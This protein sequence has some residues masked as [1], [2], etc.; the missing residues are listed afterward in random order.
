MSPS[1][2]LL[3]LDRDIYQIVARYLETETNASLRSNIDSFTIYQYIQNSNS[4]LRRRPKSILISSIDRAL[5]TMERE[6]ENRDP[7]VN[8]NKAPKKKRRRTARSTASQPTTDITIDDMGGVVHVFQQLTRK[9]AYPLHRPELLT[10]SNAALPHGILLHGPPGCGKTTIVR[11]VA[12]EAGVP[13]VEVQ[14]SSIVSSMSGE[15]EANIRSR[16]EEAKELA[17]CLLFIDDID[18]ISPKRDTSQAQMDKRM[19]SQLISCMDDLREQNKK[20]RPVIVLAATNRPGSLDPALRIGGRFGTEISI[21]VPDEAAREAILRA[22][23]RKVSYGDDVDFKKLAK[24]TVGY[25]GADLQELV[26]EAFSW[27]L[28]QYEQAMLNQEKEIE[29]DMEVD[30]VSETSINNEELKKVKTIW[31]IVKDRAKPSPPGFEILTLSMQSFIEVLP[32][33]LPFAKRQGFAAVPETTW[34]DIGALDDVREELEMSVVNQILYPED[35]AAV[36]IDAPTG[37]LLWGPPGCGKTLLA[38]ATANACQA[39]FINVKGSELLNKVR[40]FD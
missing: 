24:M 30:G 21:G 17:P 37:V 23:L 20:G 9:L 31:R 10:G 2:L 19:V 39:N 3:Q 14:G 4:S 22:Q 6:N 40:Y 33:I 38:K 15:S 34:E 13:F 35:Y 7:Q 26:D 8:D 25:V 27:S 36:G 1:T 16:F 32:K 12:A 29:K 5:E 18:A 11:A 28:E